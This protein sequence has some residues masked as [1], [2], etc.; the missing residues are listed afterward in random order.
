V[1]TLV[2]RKHPGDVITFKLFRDGKIIE[3]KVTLGQRKDDSIAA[4]DKTS[5]ES[6]EKD[7]S[8]DVSVKTLSFDNLGLTVRQMTAEE[9]KSSKVDKGIIVSESKQFSEAYNNGIV[10]GDILLEADKKDLYTPKDLKKI[11]D[12]H[13]PGDAILFRVKKSDGVGFYA[14]QIPKE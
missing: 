2:A 14:I 11:I 5:D 7:E 3:K 12:S 9:R 4:K 8:E 13:K 6:E 1:Q 10:K